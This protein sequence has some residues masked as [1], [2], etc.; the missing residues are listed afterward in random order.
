MA[1]EPQKSSASAPRKKP[2]PSR[3]LSSAVQGFLSRQPLGVPEG[4]IQKL[5]A[6]DKLDLLRV[7]AGG[8][9]SNFFASLLDELGVTYR[10]SDRDR[11][12]IPKEGP[13]V[14]V[15]NHPFGILE[16]AVL[17]DLMCS[18]RSDVKL[19]ANSL[20]GD[21]PELQEHVIGV[22][23][24]GGADAR[25]TNS[26]PLRECISWLKS[27]GMLMIFP[28][29]EV[30]A[31]TLP[32]F[33][34]ADPSW[35]ET[36]ARLIR[37]T[38]AATLP[39][40][41]HGAN[42]PLFQMA[43]LVHPRLRTAL[44]PRELLNKKNKTVSLSIGA[45]I[46]AERIKRFE[47][48][49]AAI[50]YLRRRTYVLRTRHEGPV[51]PHLHLPSP[52]ALL[53]MAAHKAELASPTPLPALCAEIDA[54][55][56]ESKL[57][58]AGDLVVYVAPAERIPAVLREI[59]RLRELTFRQ[60]GEGTGRPI[61]L[62]RF[63]QHYEHLFL[64][65]RCTNEIA[66][67][68][69]LGATDRLMANFGPR[70]LYTKTLF[71][72]DKGF[73]E[74][75]SPAL[76][77]GRSFVCPAYQKSYSPLLLLWRAIGRYVAKNPR[78]RRLFGPVSI[79]ADYGREAQEIIVSYLRSHRKEDALTG[80]VKPR[81]AFRARPLRG[82]DSRLLGSLLADPDELS[83]L[84]SD[85]EPD[86]KGIP[87]LLRQYLNL[88]GQI[89]EF[90]VDRSFSNVLDGLILVDLGQ[91]DRR[92]LDRYMGKAEAEAFRQFHQISA[93]S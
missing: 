33:Q 92:L 79:S 61:D 22:N 32:R 3:T 21:L 53:H 55:P 91:T 89:L 4:T 16:G 19:M 59:G 12:R 40:F 18:V 65:N 41:I 63:D 90:S 9:G 47:S 85:L 29:G 50:N 82:T 37:I 42:G 81:K 26:G 51:T 68:Y 34:I 58:S 2:L 8:T 77:L 1:N 35:S 71:K 17:G 48:D 75:I 80:T 6:V 67:A 44:L 84:I 43:G 7:A 87:V 69:R 30:S 57:T 36:V 86:H 39:V 10:C 76:E 88:G 72:F 24:F 93:A 52:A 27:G 38:G 83:E 11:E 49:A 13:A 23:P 56:E 20:L 28:A 46:P 66:G 15:A 74:R 5:F 60:V 73:I 54:L 70:G 14:V 45:P 25:K 78:Y 31:L 62:D 64:W